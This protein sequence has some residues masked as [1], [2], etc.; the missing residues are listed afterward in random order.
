MQIVA[1]TATFR[2]AVQTIADQG[3]LDNPVNTGTK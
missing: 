2:L 3:N 1:I